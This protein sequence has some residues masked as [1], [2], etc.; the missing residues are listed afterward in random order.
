MIPKNTRGRSFA[1]FN[2]KGE[3]KTMK[4][5]ESLCLRHLM[6]LA[7]NRISHHNYQRD[8]YREHM[9][10]E[11]ALTVP[12]DGSRPSVY[13]KYKLMKRSFPK[14]NKL[15]WLQYAFSSFNVDHI[16]GVHTDNSPDNLQ[17]LTLEMHSIK[18]QRNGDL[19]KR[20]LVTA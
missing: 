16:N 19:G 12:E 7:S 8:H 15:I 20:I 9:K 17:T 11:C 14:E 1:K 10:P 2:I 3:P 5:I 6:M 18:S 13:N 4:G